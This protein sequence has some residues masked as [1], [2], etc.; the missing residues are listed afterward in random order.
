MQWE[1]AQQLIRAGFDIVFDDDGANEAADLVCIKEETDHIRLVL[2][3]CKFSAKSTSG[4]RVKDVVE[5]ASQAIRSAR[6]P[7]RFNELVRHLQT[8]H[9]TRRVE[10]GRSLFLAGDRSS[11][12]MMLKAARFKE[13]RPEIWVVQPGISKSR[14][15]E[16]QAVVLGAAAAYLKETLAIDLRIACSK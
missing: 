8:R 5:V 10:L 14:L 15:K 16:N 13:V 7:G 6:W 3:H 1:T 4:G 12:S 9:R 11:L 2:V